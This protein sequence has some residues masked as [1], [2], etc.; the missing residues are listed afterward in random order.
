MLNCKPVDGQLRI[1]SPFGERKAPLPGASTFHQ[2]VDLGQD[3]TKTET[4][5]LAVRSGVIRSNFWNDAR[6]WVVLIDHGG[7]LSTLYQHLVDKCPLAVGETVVAGDQLGIMGNSGRSTGPHLHFE[8]RNDGK[9]VD[10]A[11]Y[12]KGVK[13]TYEEAKK[14]VQKACN[15]EQQTMDFLAAYRFR[16]PMLIKMAEAMIEKKGG[17]VN[18]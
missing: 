5:V 12:L 10:P 11:P 17:A 7:G 6:G 15:F 16:E 9:P 4:K 2:G 8:V 18:G 14:V 13:M 3:K 1:T